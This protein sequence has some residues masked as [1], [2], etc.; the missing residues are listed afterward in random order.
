MIFWEEDK[1]EKAVKVKC[2][3]GLATSVQLVPLVLLPSYKGAS[4]A[5]PHI[6]STR[7]ILR[8]IVKIFFWGF[9][10]LHKEPDLVQDHG[11]CF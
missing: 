6:G 5:S 2:K 9:V 8:R 4:P 7:Q 11:P 3:A 10:S 1:V